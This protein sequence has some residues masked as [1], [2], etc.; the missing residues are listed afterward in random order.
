MSFTRLIPTLSLKDGRVIKTVKFDQ[1]YDVGNPVTMG[2]VF[3][4]QDVDELIL[5]DITATQENREPDWI[6]IQGF[7]DECSMPLT[8]G[9]GIANLE[10]IRRLLKIGGDKVTINTQAVRNPDFISAAAGTFGSQCVVISIDAKQY[11]KGQYEV[12]VNGGHEQTGLDAVTWAKICEEKGAGEIFI[13]SI[14]SDGTMEG[15]DLELVEIISTAVN[16]PVIA[17]GGAGLL[18]DLL[19][20]VRKGKASAVACSSIFCFTDN[21][22]IKVKSFLQDQGLAVRPI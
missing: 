5:T 4:S 16:I 3:D 21:K 2:K 11:A 15:Y 7:A 1:Y 22:P 14:D 12:L 13:T 19:D 10:H 17:S 8:V 20:V 18:I 9:G 6:N